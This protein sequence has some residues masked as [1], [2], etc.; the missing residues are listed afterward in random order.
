MNQNQLE[1][2]MLN[3]IFRSSQI[4]NCTF[5][6]QNQACEKTSKFKVIM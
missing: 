5:C 2:I 4:H 6:T 3:D 1:H